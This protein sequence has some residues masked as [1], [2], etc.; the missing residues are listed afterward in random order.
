MIFGA[1]MGEMPVLGLVSSGASSVTCV[2]AAWLGRGPQMGYWPE[3]LHVASQRVLSVCVL[4]WVSS[5]HGGVVFLAGATG[6]QRANAWD[7]CHLPKL[8]GEAC[9]P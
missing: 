7:V 6:Q 9:R 4:I 8:K 2:A 3:H 1:S 5:P